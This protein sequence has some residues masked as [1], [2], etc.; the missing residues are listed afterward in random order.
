[1]NAKNGVR[2]DATAAAVAPDGRK[3][4][5]VAVGVRWRADGAVLLADRPVG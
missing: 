2:A 1:M 3:V 4:T 5:E